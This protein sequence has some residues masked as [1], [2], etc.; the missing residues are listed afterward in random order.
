MYRKKTKTRKRLRVISG[1]KTLAIQD[2]GISSI[3][4]YLVAFKNWK[5][6]ACNVVLARPNLGLSLVHVLKDSL[7]QKNE[8]FENQIFFIN[9]TFLSGS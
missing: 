4:F 6:N 7:L 9:V 5:S 2:Y 8:K 3:V 1:P